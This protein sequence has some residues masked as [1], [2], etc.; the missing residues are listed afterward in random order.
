M[1]CV[2]LGK[3]SRQRD[4]ES[5]NI[6]IWMTCE[7]Y[8]INPIP[9]LGKKN[10]ANVTKNQDFLNFFYFFEKIIKKFDKK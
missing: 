7:S 1:L 6:S 5:E 8:Q 10:I 4:R 9:F 2:L 3:L